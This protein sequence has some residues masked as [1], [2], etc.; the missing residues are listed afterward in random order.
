[1]NAKRDKM[2]PENEYDSPGVGTIA[3]LR[4]RDA[5]DVRTDLV[6]K[7]VLIL[8]NKGLISKDIV[9]PVESRSL[10][11]QLNEYINKYPVR[12]HEKHWVD[13]GEQIAVLH[14]KTYLPF[15]LNV[16]GSKI[17]RLCDG[18]HTIEKIISQLKNEW[19]LQPEKVLVRDLMR[20]LL[21]LEELD[22]I[23]FVG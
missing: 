5:E 21:L 20:Y 16:S 19:H 13:G 10:R 9:P 15:F 8:E 22:L 18:E 11:I 2:P 23:E 14:P 7:I 3:P 1:M 17:C 12:K 6:K 4:S